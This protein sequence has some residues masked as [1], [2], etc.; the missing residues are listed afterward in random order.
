MY[1]TAEEL[2]SVQHLHRRTPYAIAG[3]SRSIF[4][5]A[6]L[7][8]GTSYNG[9]PYTYIA[10][11]DELVR[12]DVLAFVRRQRRAADKAAPAAGQAQQPLLNGTP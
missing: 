5:V 6:R 4:S 7:Y 3:V 12:D 8:G 10:E 9:C 1:L 11:H 2:Q